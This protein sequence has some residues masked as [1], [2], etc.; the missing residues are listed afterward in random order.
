[1]LLPPVVVGVGSLGRLVVEALRGVICDRYGALDKV[2]HVRF[3]YIDTDPEAGSLSCGSPDTPAALTAKE[4]VFARLNRPT[5][6]L[7]R[8]SLPAVEQWLPRG[9]LYKISRNPGAASGVRAFGRLAFFDNYRLVAQRVRQEL[10]TFLTDDS[11]LKAEDTTKL[12][13]R[14]NRPRAYVVAGLGGGTGGGMFLDLAFLIRQ[15]LRG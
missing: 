3:L 11:L 7:Q 8:E 9:A 13:L 5:H 12:G 10:D 15:E 1:A 6:Y 4:L 2:P 14:T